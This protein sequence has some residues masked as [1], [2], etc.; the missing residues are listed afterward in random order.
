MAETSAWELGRGEGL[1][2][3]GSSMARSFSR[4][5]YAGN[6]SGM[7]ESARRGNVGYG[8]Q[9]LEVLPLAA[10]IS[11]GGVQGQERQQPGGNQEGLIW[12]ER[13]QSSIDRLCHLLPELACD[14]INSIKPLFLSL[15]IVKTST[16]CSAF[17]Q[18]P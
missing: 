5:G 13:L 11:P 12:L 6:S 7:D 8:Q 18:P 17:C 10:L 4:R 16:S 3:L 1:S 15:A 9:V 2:S 14:F